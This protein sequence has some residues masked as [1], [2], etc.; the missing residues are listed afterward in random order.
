MVSAL[1]D[2]SGKSNFK[3]TQKKGS[4]TVKHFSS[5]TK[6]F[7]DEQRAAEQAAPEQEKLAQDLTGASKID[8]HIPPPSI[9]SGYEIM[10]APTGEDMVHGMAKLKVDDGQE[11]RKREKKDLKKIHRNEKKRS[12]RQVTSS[13][14]SGSDDDQEFDSS[15]YVLDV[16]YFSN[17]RQVEMEIFGENRD[18]LVSVFPSSIK[19]EKC[20][21]CIVPLGI[22]S[23]M[24]R[25]FG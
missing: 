6:S 23:H 9:S 10:F 1:D 14:S 3:E 24:P 7:F 19:V 11:E 5:V 20:L 18:V 17:Y 4:N 12:Y 8:G 13:S 22:N 25:R 2:A 15:K 21:L 16:S